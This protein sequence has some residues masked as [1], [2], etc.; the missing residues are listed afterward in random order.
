MKRM[1]TNKLIDKIKSLF[2]SVSTDDDGNVEIGKNLEV[3]GEIATNGYINSANI[4]LHSLVVKAYDENENE[5]QDVQVSI[6]V[7]NFADTQNTGVDTGVYKKAF[8]AL[9]SDAVGIKSI[10]L[11]DR[12]GGVFCDNVLIEKAVG[13]TFNDITSTTTTNGNVITFA[14][15]NSIAT[16]ELLAFLA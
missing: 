9:E 10:E 16:V 7:M 15:S 5:L 11:F 6:F 4:P 8:V 2:T 12:D 1:I 14:S 13:E 3:D